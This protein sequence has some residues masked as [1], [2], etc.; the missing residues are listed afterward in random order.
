[1][2]SMDI[3]VSNLIQFKLEII[4]SQNLRGRGDILVIFLVC[5]SISCNIK[6]TNDDCE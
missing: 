4:L 2:T 1:M 3:K 5:A 6:M